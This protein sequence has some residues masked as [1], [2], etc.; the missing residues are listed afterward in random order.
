MASLVDNP[1]RGRHGNKL[2]MVST[3]QEL[4]HIHV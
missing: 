2:T 3:V 4:R 1:V